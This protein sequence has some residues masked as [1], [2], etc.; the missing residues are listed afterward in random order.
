MEKIQN[1]SNFQTMSVKMGKFG[2]NFPK[3]QK[4]FMYCFTPAMK[5]ALL[6]HRP[7]ETMYVVAGIGSRQAS[8]T[9]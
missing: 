3:T 6:R 7:V 5:E 9:V 2:G 8:S 4:C 1:L